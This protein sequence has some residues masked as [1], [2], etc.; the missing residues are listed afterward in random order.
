MMIAIKNAIIVAVGCLAA[1][2]YDRIG[3]IIRYTGTLCAAVL[4]YFLPCVIRIIDDRQETGHYRWHIVAFHAL[5][6]VYGVVN[7]IIQFTV[8]V[9]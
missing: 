1:M 6:I 4:M 2:F 7:F 8:N 5:L 3:D 9:Y